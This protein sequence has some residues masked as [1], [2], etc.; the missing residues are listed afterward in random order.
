M[1][2]DDMERRTMRV[3][4][5]GGRIGAAEAAAAERLRATPCDSLAWLRAD[6]TGEAASAFDTV[7]E[8]AQ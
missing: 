8:N 5:L 6:L 4:S 3:V 7:R 1:R 2:S